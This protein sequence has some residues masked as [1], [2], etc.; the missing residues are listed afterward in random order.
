MDKSFPSAP[1]DVAP[2]VYQSFVGR[3]PI[4]NRE[5]DVIAYELLF[6]NSEENIGQFVDGDQATSQVLLNACLDIGLDTLVGSRRAFVNVTRDFLLQDH[7]LALPPERVGLEFV[8]DLLDIDPALF[9]KIRELSVQG[10]T[11]SLDSYIYDEELNPLLE[12]VDWIKL[13]VSVVDHATLQEQVALLSEYDVALVAGR[14]ETLEEFAYCR[15]LGF[16]YFQGFFLHKPDVVQ[17]ERSPT[18]R[19]TLLPLMAKL[20]DPDLDFDDLETLVSRDATL[21]YKLLRLINSAVY[22]RGSK[23]ESIRQALMRLGITFITNW[24]N[25]IAMSGFDDQPSDLMNTAMVRARM[26]ELLAQ[27]EARSEQAAFFTVGLFS[28]LDVLMNRSMQ[29]LLE[30][31]PLADGLVAALLHHE[32]KLGAALSCVLAYERGDWDAVVYFELDHT[33]IRDAYLGAI[34]W[35][36]E[37]EA[38]IAGV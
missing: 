3:Q 1:S 19:L 29:D 6:R 32:G 21:S 11:I 7:A 22:A 26:C 17:G 20:Q 37:M 15:D 4:Y 14:V 10:Y 24:V 36:S 16:E 34:A 8:G 35:A 2:Q 12:F 33:A 27:D 13:D 23:V 28:V 31:L 38:T 30:D 9:N 18:S 5:L 25:L